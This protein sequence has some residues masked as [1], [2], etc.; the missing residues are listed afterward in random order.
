M[1]NAFKVGDKV[2][3]VAT[4][5]GAKSVLI[6]GEKYVVV[7]VGSDREFWN[8]D[9]WIMVSGKFGRLDHEYSKFA[10]YA[11]QFVKIPTSKRNLPEWF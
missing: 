6:V 9:D 5:T 1:M 2:L 3:C 11:R 4:E 10:W 7:A 8:N